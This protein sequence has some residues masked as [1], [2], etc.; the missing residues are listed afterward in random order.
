MKMLFDYDEEPEPFSIPNELRW[1]MVHAHAVEKGVA[2][3]DANVPDWYMRMKAEVLNLANAHA[4]VCG[5]V[6]NE[7]W[8][9]EIPKELRERAKTHPYT[10]GVH[11]FSPFHFAMN[12]YD[13]EAEEYGFE[14]QDGLIE[15]MIKD[16]DYYDDAFKASYSLLTEMWITAAQKRR[17][18]AGRMFD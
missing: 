11:E 3:L 8:E 15:E 5:Q 17:A 13:I 1:E 18:D 10:F 12:K 2:F 9:T 14:S 16:I 7:M 6:F 4:C